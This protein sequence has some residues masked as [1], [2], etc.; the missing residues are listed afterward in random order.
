MLIRFMENTPIME[1]PTEE[2]NDLM[3]GII[4]K[5]ADYKNYSN[6]IGFS[7]RY[8]KIIETFLRKW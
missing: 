5:V 8:C 3:V 2:I 7:F 6:L 4:K 1:S